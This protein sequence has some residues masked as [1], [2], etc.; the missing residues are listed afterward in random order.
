[1]SMPQQQFNPYISSPT[2][3]SHSTNI[4]RSAGRSASISMGSRPSTY[5]CI[6]CKTTNV[7]NEN[8][9]NFCSVCRSA[10]PF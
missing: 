2:S 3:I 6:G 9:R 5:T 4:H 8:G 7:F 1:M 10:A